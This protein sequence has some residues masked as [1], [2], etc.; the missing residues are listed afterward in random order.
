MGCISLL[1]C[2]PVCSY[3]STCLEWVLCVSGMPF[4]PSD[5]LSTHILSCYVGAE[6][7]FIDLFQ[8]CSV[9]CTIF[10]HTTSPD[11]PFPSSL[12]LTILTSDDTSSGFSFHHPYIISIKYSS[13]IHP[14]IGVP[15]NYILWSPSVASSLNLKYL[16]EIDIYILK[17]STLQPS[18]LFFV[19]GA[20]H[21]SPT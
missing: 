16:F 15:L 5:L 9:I 12:F 18:S 1:L 6:P 3:T 13:C 21:A 17:Y 20:T 14:K 11:T 19:F 4:A 10:R 7:R 2:S 8:R